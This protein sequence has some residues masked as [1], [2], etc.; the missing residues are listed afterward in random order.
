MFLPRLRRPP[1]WTETH[2]IIHW[3][4]GGLTDL[5]NITLLCGFHHRTHETQGW[6]CRKINGTSHTWLPT[7]WLEP[8]CGPIR[9]QTH[10]IT[11]YVP[12]AAA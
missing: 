4:H 9:N 7:W 1:Q 6:E 2:H 8:T 10:H 11:D 12:A 3:A 5:T